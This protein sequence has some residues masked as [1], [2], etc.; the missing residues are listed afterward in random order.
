MQ[1]N[2]VHQFSIWLSRWCRSKPAVRC[3]RAQYTLLHL[4]QA[5]RRVERFGPMLGFE[6]ASRAH[7]TKDWDRVETFPVRNLAPR[8][9]NKSNI[10][11]EFPRFLGAHN[12]DLWPY[13][14]LEHPSG[15]FGVSSFLFSMEIMELSQF[16]F[17]KP[18]VQN[19]TTDFTAR[20]GRDGIL[21]I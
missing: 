10:R 11:P 5:Y 14:A 18:H 20:N 4:K 2:H 6:I 17:G 12:V 16:P 19:Q 3:C 21:V 1:Y 15:R 8:R 13:W 7:F 9:S